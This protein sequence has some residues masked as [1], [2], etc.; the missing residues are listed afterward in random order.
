MWEMPL[1]ILAILVVVISVVMYFVL[2]PLKVLGARE[3]TISHCFI[4]IGL[5]L[6]SGWLC[7][8]PGI[9]WNAAMLVGGIWTLCGGLCFSAVYI[10]RKLKKSN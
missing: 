2:R 10:I 7:F 8:N 9:Q 5:L 4:I 6:I 1:W 3:W